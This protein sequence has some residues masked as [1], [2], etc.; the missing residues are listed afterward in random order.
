MHVVKPRGAILGTRGDTANPMNLEHW[1]SYY[2]SGALVSCPTNPEPY[3]TM[4]VRE[5]W[6]EFFGELCDGDRI[7]DLGTGNGPVTLIAK[8]TAVKHARQFAITGVDLAAIDPQR[9]VPDGE[10][11][12]S[13][14]DFHAGVSVEALPFDAHSFD[15]ISGQYILEY[16]DVERTLGECARVLRPTGKCRFILHHLESII[17]TNALESLRQADM[18]L[19]ETRTLRKFRR[20]CERAHDSRTR[21]ERARG[22]LMEAG[23]HLQQV[24]NQSLNPVLLKFVI[25][26]VSGLLANRSRLGRGQMLHQTAVLERELKAW[27]SRLQDLVSAALSEDELER[28]VDL[29]GALGLP[30]IDRQL[31]W[32]GGSNLVGWRLTLA[33]RD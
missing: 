20:Y 31:Q 15:A 30:E 24:A 19:H 17:V 11:L 1:A 14:I 22:Q 5:A 8:E 16:T 28:V 9:F 32:Q 13:G 18:V 12:L 2:R 23:E 3:Y 6:A 29:A 33:R 25:A 26:G 10:K 4:E 7:L 21:A 27:V